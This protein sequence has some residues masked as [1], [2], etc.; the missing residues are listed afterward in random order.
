MMRRERQKKKSVE[1][2]LR[3]IKDKKE[4]SKIRSKIFIYLF[5]DKI[6]RK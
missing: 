6:H 4:K 5:F 1:I 2:F 3:F